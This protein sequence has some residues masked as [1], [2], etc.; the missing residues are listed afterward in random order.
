MRRNTGR[1]TNKKKT[2][3]Q[4]VAQ[5]HDGPIP[6]SARQESPRPWYHVGADDVA[7]HDG[8]DEDERWEERMEPFQPLEHAL[9]TVIPDDYPP[10]FSLS[11]QMDRLREVGEARAYTT[12]AEDDAELVRRLAG[13]QAV[14]NMRSFT[15]FSAEVFAACPELRIISI[16]G[17]GTDNVDLEAAAQQGI[18]VCNTPEA[19]SDSVAE[20]TWALLLGLARGVREMEERMR[21]GEWWHYYGIELR[22]KT[23]G[24]IGLGR[25]ARRVAAIGHGFAMRVIAWSFTH[26]ENR[27]RDAGAELVELDHL[28]ATADV[29]SLHLR[30]SDRSLGILGDAELR[31]MKSTALL[32][33]TARGALTDELALARALSE[34][35]MA[36]AA[37]D[38]YGE[39][40][41]PMDHPLR[42]APNT[43]LIPHAGWMTCEARERMLSEPVDNILA[44]LDGTPQNVVSASSG[45]E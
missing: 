30:L 44:W 7:H 1:N 18:L 42:S 14:V 34:G 15:R 8:G 33:N 26:D 25:V 32:V 28:L 5:I 21:S 16:S 3:A 29:V 4:P 39:E 11:A 22:G 6:A 45:R 13:A 27:G 2:T 41:L 20:H 38:C 36:G 35:R 31:R 37:L 40:P 19:N 43:L 17:T 24:L 10:V 23:L 9:A 12:R